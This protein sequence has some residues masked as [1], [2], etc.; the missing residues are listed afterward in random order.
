MHFGLTDEQQQLRDIAKRLLADAPSLRQRMERKGG[1]VYDDGTWQ[2]MWEEQGW[3]VMSLPE[4]DGDRCDL[5]T[6]L[7]AEPPPGDR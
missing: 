5:A 1:H 7:G 6:L 4:D 3:P 2:Q